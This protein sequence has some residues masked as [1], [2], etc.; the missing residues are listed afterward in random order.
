MPH[1]VP[2]PF[3]AAVASVQQESKQDPRR[4][5]WK[6]KWAV[7][8]LEI[9]ST[10]SLL[11]RDQDLRRGVACDFQRHH[12]PLLRLLCVVHETGKRAECDKCDRCKESCEWMPPAQP[13]CLTRHDPANFKAVITGF[14][15]LGASARRELAEFCNRMRARTA[16]QPT[17][18]LCTEG[19]TEAGSRLTSLFCPVIPSNVQIEGLTSRTSAGNASNYC[20]PAN[21]I[22]LDP[23][24]SS[25][26]CC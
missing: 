10:R 22:F 9:L 15:K 26:R 11:A 20:V 3:R 24:P 6:A 14:S 16:I 21:T 7:R 17:A 8:G 12:V 1:R 23:N 19:S 18:L 2:E 5:T 25:A 13:S 4:R